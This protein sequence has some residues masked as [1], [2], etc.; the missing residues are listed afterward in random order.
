M[1]IGTKMFNFLIK[2]PPKDKNINIVQTDPQYLWYKEV[3]PDVY[4]PTYGE[5]FN[6]GYMLMGHIIKKTSSGS[7]N[8]RLSNRDFTQFDGG[9]I[10]EL[11]P[12]LLRQVSNSSSNQICSISTPQKYL[13]LLG[14]LLLIWF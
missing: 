9:Q 4:A 3:L 10:P 6:A 7:I 5:E 8:I 14:L 12:G 2:N 11:V 1:L 13:L